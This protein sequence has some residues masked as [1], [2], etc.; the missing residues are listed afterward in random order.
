L[1]ERKVPILSH[2]LVLAC[3]AVTADFVCGIPGHKQTSASKDALYLNQFSE[4]KIYLELTHVFQTID[5]K[6]LERVFPLPLQ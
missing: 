4:S 2:G 1:S 3:L 5:S 6:L